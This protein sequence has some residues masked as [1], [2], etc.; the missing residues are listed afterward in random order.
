MVTYRDPTG[1]VT[2]LEVANS[3]TIG[4]DPQ[5]A[6]L[7]LTPSDPAVSGVAVVLAVR[8]AHVVVMNTST[9]AQLDVLHEQGTRFLFPGE[10]LATTSSVSI[11]VPGSIYVHVVNVEVTGA[12]ARAESPTG[13]KPLMSDPFSIPAERYLTLVGL[14]TA[15]FRPERF[16]VA[17]LTATQIAELISKSGDP[18]TPKAVNNKLQRLRDDIAARLGIYLDTRDDLADWAIRNGY[19][20]RSDVD[21]LL[22]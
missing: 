1:S 6:S 17:L 18:V 4:R 21:E 3:L 20:S 13:T 7:V 19:V 5:R 15:R 12:P 22:G 2:A 10:E 9:Y 11:S 16:G 14:C 8:D